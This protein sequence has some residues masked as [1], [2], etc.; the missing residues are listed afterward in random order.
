MY[1]RSFQLKRAAELRVQAQAIYYNKSDLARTRDH[2]MPTIEAVR[3]RIRKGFASI[4]VIKRVVPKPGP[5]SGGPKK[6]TGPAICQSADAPPEQAG[7]KVS[8]AEGG[9]CQPWARARLRHVDC[10]PGRDP[11]E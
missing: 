8:K 7:R 9:G 1:L 3:G 2:M 4:N 11:A 10:G 6:W 5:G